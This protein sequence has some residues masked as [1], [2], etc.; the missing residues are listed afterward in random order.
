MDSEFVATFKFWV[1]YVTGESNNQ[2]K[3]FFR[4]SNMVLIRE[5]GNGN[6]AV[7]RRHRKGF[8]VH[9]INAFSDDLLFFV[10]Y[11]VYSWNEVES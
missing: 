1:I 7:R 6:W 4:R 2:T 8:K 3:T 11:V 10:R 9:F 5:A